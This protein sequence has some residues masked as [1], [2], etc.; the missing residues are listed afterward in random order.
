MK[1]ED[2]A[3]SLGFRYPLARPS[4]SQ[5]RARG[6]APSRWDSA[7]HCTENGAPSRDGDSLPP[8]LRRVRITASRLRGREGLGRGR[9]GLGRGRVWHCAVLCCI[10]LHRIARYVV[11]LYC[12]VLY[13]IVWSMWLN[14]VLSRHVVLWY[15][16]PYHDM[17][18]M[19]C[20]HYYRVGTSSQHSSGS[21][22]EQTSWVHL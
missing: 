14:V 10:A 1:H 19:I 3:H 9:E 4:G 15:A 20:M 7:P 21:S 2:L 11:V 16:I 12:T 18:T 13:C 8:P 22:S 5:Q 17:T 6:R